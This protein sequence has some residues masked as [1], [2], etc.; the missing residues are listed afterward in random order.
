MTNVA[1]PSGSSLSGSRSVQRELRLDALRREFGVPFALLEPR[2]GRVMLSPDGFPCDLGA[3]Y[4]VQLVRRVAADGQAE[5][6]D[7][8]GD[9]QLLAVPIWRRDRVRAVA[10]GAV[11]GCDE[12]RSHEVTTSQAASQTASHRLE[13]WAQSYADNQRLNEQLRCLRAQSVETSGRRLAMLDRLAGR[14]AIS[15]DPERFQSLALRAVAESLAAGCFAWAPFSRSAPMTIVGDAPL[16][17]EMI[18]DLIET[19][20]ARCS[21]DHGPAMIENN[22]RATSWGGHLDGVYSVVIVGPEANK[23]GGR[24]VVINKRSSEPFDDQD[25]ALLRPVATLLDMQHRN[26][27]TYTDLKELL[28]GVVRALASAIDAKDQYTRGHSERVARVAVCL[29]RQLRLGADELSNLYLAGLLHDVGKIGVG[30]EVLKKAGSLTDCEYQHVT[31]HVEIGVSILRELKR[32]RHVLPGVRHHHERYDGRGYPDKLSGEGI[33]LI[34]RILA[35]ADA[36][37]AMSSDR[38]YRTRRAPEEVADNLR[39]GAGQQWD[40]KVVAAALACWDEIMAIGQRGLGQSLRVAVDDALR[41]DYPRPQSS[42]V[43]SAEQ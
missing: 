17:S 28:F 7:G 24:L 1:A 34:A 43:A 29:G 30:D 27:S 16:P 22:V 42:L 40:P 19:A 10:I 41:Q 3:P 5:L 18:R 23:F 4:V 31:T 39:R 33:P 37:D 2:W 21:P 11:K 13:R 14:L 35:V 12:A 20:S 8:R 36:F 32:L 9:C 25:V 15:D 26:S 6:Y 38:A